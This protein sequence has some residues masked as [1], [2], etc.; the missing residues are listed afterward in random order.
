MKHSDFKIGTVFNSCTGQRWRC[1]DVG[2][3][4]I[5]AI[6]LKPELDS[7]WFVGPPYAVVEVSFDEND[8][9]GV[10]RNDD[11]AIQDAID[12]ADNSNHPG[13]PNGIVKTFS[14]ARFSDDFH[15]YPNKRLL[16]ND[17]VTNNGEILHPY[18]AELNHDGWSVLVYE[19]FSRAFSK[20]HES[21]FI[22]LRL[23]TE[24]DLRKRQRVFKQSISEFMNEALNDID[25][26]VP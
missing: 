26:W 5:L 21:E 25:G 8:M 15:A 19:L 16:K 17:R 23:S 13:F 18:G 1:T 20:V 22:Q 10:Y 3:R 4:T 24:N 2:T 11:E 12:D 6:E 7:S 9:G 14:K